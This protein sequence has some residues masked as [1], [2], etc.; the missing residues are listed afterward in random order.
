M[1]EERLGFGGR[2]NAEAFCLGYYSHYFV[3]PENRNNG[4]IPAPYSIQNLIS[5][6]IWLVIKT[7]TH[8]D[9]IVQNENAQSR[10]SSIN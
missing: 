2:K 6:G 4:L 5:V 10:P 9:R 7:P 1:I 8:G 3:K